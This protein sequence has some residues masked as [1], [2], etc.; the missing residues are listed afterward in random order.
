MAHFA[1][2][3]AVKEVEVA[4]HTVGHFAALTTSIVVVHHFIR[5]AGR[6]MLINKVH[7]ITCHAIYAD[8]LIILHVAGHTALWTLD[9]ALNQGAVENW[10]KIEASGAQIAS[11]VGFQLRAQLA[12]NDAGVACC[13]GAI[14]SHEIAVSTYGTIDFAVCH[15]VYA[16]LAACQ[17]IAWLALVDSLTV[18]QIVSGIAGYT[19]LVTVNQAAVVTSGGIVVTA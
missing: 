7:I 4:E 2:D 6:T 10:N 13:T 17:S 19:V 3:L 18:N 5:K 15:K 14:G 11:K 8:D 1:Y 12:S 16:F 9:T